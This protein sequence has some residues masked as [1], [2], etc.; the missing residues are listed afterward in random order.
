MLKID[1]ISSQLDSIDAKLADYAFFPISQVLKV[2]QKVTIQCL[3]LCLECIPNLVEYGWRADLPPPLAAQLIILCTLLAQ[4][5]PKGFS[6]D[7]TTAELQAAAYDCIRAVCAAVGP[8]AKMLLMAEANFPQLG[9]TISSILDGIDDGGSNQVQVAASEALRVMVKDILDRELCAGFLP[10]MVSKMTR[11]LTPTTKQ[12]RGHIVLVS[13]M[14]T[15][16]LLIRTTLSDGDVVERTPASVFVHS[17]NAKSKP[18]T[19]TT[20]WKKTAATQLVTALTPIMRLG[21]SS[22]QEVQNAL[23]QF[24]EMLLEHCRETLE[25][26]SRLALDTIIT[27]STDQVESDARS[28]LNL[29]LHRDPSL[30]SLMQSTLYDWLQSLAT[31]MQ[32]ADPEAKVLKLRRIYTAYSLLVD[33]SANTDII[34]KLMGSSLR[35]SIILTLQVPIDR[36]QQS[37]VSS[38][39]SMSMA[40]LDRDLQKTEFTSPLVK[41]RGQEDILNNIE[42]LTKMINSTDKSSAFMTDMARTLHTSHGEAQLASLWLLLT[43]TEASLQRKNA[44][45]GFLVIEGDIDDLA[46]DHLEQLYSFSLSVLTDAFDEPP[47]S[48]LQALALRS[49]ALRARISGADFRYELIDALYP[50]LHTLATPDNLL[51]SD[52][53]TTL[54]IFTTSCGYGSIKELIVENVDYL[55]NAVALKLNAFDVSPQGPQVLLMMVRLAGP[56]LLPYLEDTIES[57]F[58]VLEYYHG[59]PLLVELLFKVLTVVAD[60]GTKAPQL[61]IPNGSVDASNALLRERWRAFSVNEL[62]EQLQE[63]AEEAAGLKLENNTVGHEPHP[64]RPWKRFEEVKDDDVDEDGQQRETRDNDTDRATDETDLPPP[65]PKTYAL[66]LKITDLTQHF[67]PSASSS[68]RASLL[69]LITTTVPAIAQHENSFLPLINTLWPEVVSRLDDPEPHVRVMA[70]EVVSV[71]CGHAGDFMRSR[72]TAL[73]PRMV[74]IHDSIAKDIT[75]GSR[76]ARTGKNSSS[77]IAVVSATQ[78]KL[79]VSEMQN[80]SADYTNTSVRILWS[81]FVTV[82]ASILRSVEVE[83]EI[84]DEALDLLAP[85]LDDD[86]VR[87]ALEQ[88]NA[89]AVWLASMRSDDHI[90]PR[91]PNVPDGVAWHFAQIPA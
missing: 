54:N 23:V 25:N 75:V 80:S 61:A 83:A 90:M 49:L 64:H 20:D 34:D 85:A 50:V 55:T 12:R 18:S 3:E 59:Y 76:V 84:F 1:S 26:C 39:Q 10:G 68:L 48:R 82:L 47:D 63:Q 91:R 65:A 69:A 29:L 87:L 22:R 21:N 71:L 27:I 13:C 79:A 24:C 19:I 30:S 5:R 9:H 43:A 4:K 28:S 78:L 60:E 66:L 56:S 42:N 8:E 72:I 7:H 16:T 2:S 31:T 88:E 38:T 36:P 33:A 32:S 44:T 58:A 6:F 46:N 70:L 77:T 73:W 57:I 35:D 15:L 62:N 51:Q 74:E 89:D 40:T 67:L 11:I 14:N 37:F 53:I 17:R 86:V 41:Y 45:S 81:A 52:S